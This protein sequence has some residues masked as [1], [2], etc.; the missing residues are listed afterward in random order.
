MDVA[1]P[2]VLHASI[3]TFQTI[4]LQYLHHVDQNLDIPLTTPPT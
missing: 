4:P 2:T 1:I 3:Q